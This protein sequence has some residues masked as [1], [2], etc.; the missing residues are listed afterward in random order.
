MQG[1]AVLLVPVPPLESW[2]VKRTRHY[3]TGFV[4]QDAGFGHA[5]LT[6]LAPFPV[7]RL[8]VARACAEVVEPFDYE[9]ARVDVFPDGIIHLLPE[10]VEG[11]RQL[12]RHARRLLPNVAPYWGRATDPPPH[13]T[14]DM[15]G[16]QGVT[17]ENTLASI[18]QLPVAARAD[19][20]QLTWWES[21]ACRLLAT[22]PLGAAS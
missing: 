2:V 20:L 17:V 11:F 1:H 22:I 3:D 6:V 18:P 13:V 12:L 16:Q 9:L 8:D 4:S 7:E 15:A 10:P 19:E 5:H 21:G 14:L